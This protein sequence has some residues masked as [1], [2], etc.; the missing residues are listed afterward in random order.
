MHMLWSLACMT[1]PASFSSDWDAVMYSAP[2]PQVQ[3]DIHTLHVHLTHLTSRMRKP[4]GVTTYSSLVMSRA[5]ADL[6]STEALISGKN[7]SVARLLR[8]AD[9]LSWEDAWQVTVWHD[10]WGLGRETVPL[11]AS[12]SVVDDVTRCEQVKFLGDARFDIA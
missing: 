5:L 10:L 9:A 2:D 1:G 12:K 3:L 11:K 8:D 7:A 4:D 6:A